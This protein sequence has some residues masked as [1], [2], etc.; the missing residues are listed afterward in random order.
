[1]SLSLSQIVFRSDSKGVATTNKKALRRRIKT[2]TLCKWYFD[3]MRICLYH[4]FPW[5]LWRGIEFSYIYSYMNV[6]HKHCTGKNIKTLYHT[7]LNWLYCVKRHKFI[8]PNNRINSHKSF[9]VVWLSSYVNMHSIDE[10]PF[11]R[12]I[13]L[14]FLQHS[15]RKR[16]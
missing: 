7:Q 8:R 9:R 15:T 11:T 2:L 5:N 14:P 12:F 16:Q 3:H 1:M 4:I 13:F 10:M 6:K